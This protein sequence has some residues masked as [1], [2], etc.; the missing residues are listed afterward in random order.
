MILF[1]GRI[2]TCMLCVFVAACTATPTPTLPPTP[3]IIVSTPTPSE[4][5]APTPQPSATT[6]MPFTVGAVSADE[7]WLSSVR[8]VADKLGA[9]WL[10]SAE[11]SALVAQGVQVLILDEAASA[12][13]NALAQANPQVFIVAR[14]NF[15]LAETPPN[16]LVLGGPA[17]REDQAGFLA[18]M[19]AGFATEVERVA[20]VSDPSVT[21]GKKY[22]N[23]FTAGVR[24]TCPKCQIDLVDFPA[25]TDAPT[26]SAAVQKTA[27]LGTDVFWIA[28]GG[29]AE[30]AFEALAGRNVSLLA[31]RAP[32]AGENFLVSVTLDFPA[33][34]S[35]A[36]Q[37][38]QAGQPLSGQQ[39]FSLASGNITFTVHLDPNG[40]L[41][42]LDLRDIETAREKLAS[43]ALE[44]G[45]DPLTGEEK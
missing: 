41:S 21:F 43:G 42:I 26:V 14:S 16:L 17:S 8:P 11:A 31:G 38:Y 3:N 30:A 34:L 23:G 10:E 37:N 28:P 29:Y 32:Y 7:G 24:Y 20:V 36:L 40:R 22:R 45:V 6:I 4:A 2:L 9:R 5:I 27:A 15:S 25:I 13:A 12:Q 1:R 35:T 44:T 19:A 33:A 18:G 39:P